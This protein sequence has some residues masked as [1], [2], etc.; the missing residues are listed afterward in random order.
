M[1][2]LIYSLGNSPLLWLAQKKI[3]QNLN[4][5]A[6]WNSIK[7]MCAPNSSIFQ[8]CVAEKPQRDRQ[9]QSASTKRY[10]SFI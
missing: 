6:I 2:M 9:V 1:I 8:T 10:S 4:V 3:K 5:L 7:Y